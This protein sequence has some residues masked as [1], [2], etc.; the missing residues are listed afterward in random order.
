MIDLAAKQYTVGS[1]SQ[2]IMQNADDPQSNQNSQ[3]HIG[4]EPIPALKVA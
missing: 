4:S 3:N 2:S 1:N